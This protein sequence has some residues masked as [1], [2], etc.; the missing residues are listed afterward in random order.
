MV[1]FSKKRELDRLRAAQARRVMPLVSQLLEVWEQIP[2][3]VKSGMMELAPGIVGNIL[4]LDSVM[5]H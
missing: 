4:A 3:D 2:N 1:L 5:E